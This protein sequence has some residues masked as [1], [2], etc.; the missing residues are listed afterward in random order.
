MTS[1]R[2][3][4]TMGWNLLVDTDVERLVSPLPEDQGPELKS[5]VSSETTGEG[6]GRHGRG[7]KVDV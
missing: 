4:E 7:E 6:K 1:T 2:E 3:R 5:C